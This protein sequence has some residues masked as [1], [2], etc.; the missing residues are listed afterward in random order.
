MRKWMSTWIGF[1]MWVLAGTAARAESFAYQCAAGCDEANLRLLAEAMDRLPPLVRSTL[2]APVAVIFEALPEGTAGS[3]DLDWE[4]RP[5]RPFRMRVHSG[6]DIT[7]RL[8]SLLHETAHLFD[9]GQPL[10]ESERWQLSTCRS[11]GNRGGP[12][13]ARL[14]GKRG[15]YSDDAQFQ[16][17]AGWTLSP[18]GIA[19]RTNFLETRSPDRYEFRDPREAFAVNFEYFLLDPEFACRRPAMRRYLSRVTGADPF[20]EARCRQ[21]PSEGALPDLSRLAEVQLL[22]ATPGEETASRWGHVMFRLVFC[23]PERREVSLECRKDLSEH[24]IISPRATLDGFSQSAWKLLT[25]GYDSQ[26]YVLKFTQV[27]RQYTRHEFRDL[28]AI[29]LRLSPEE[30]SAFGQVALERFW[31]YRG[32]YRLLSNNCADE[33]L[34]LLQAALGRPELLEINPPYLT[35][36][37]LAEELQRLGLAERESETYASRFPQLAR[38]VAELDPSVDVMSLLAKSP[39]AR[40]VWGESRVDASPTLAERQ[41]RLANL[42]LVE[43]V[44]EGRLRADLEQR[45]LSHWWKEA[46]VEARSRLLNPESPAAPG[47]GIPQAGEREQGGVD[48]GPEILALAQKREAAL[49]SSWSSS[50]SLRKRWLSELRKLQ[51]G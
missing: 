36:H 9:L 41:A 26:V 3:T 13:C 21:A 31:T 11:T 4:G 22:L 28:V 37:Q 16:A 46:P 45:T 48:L 15:K 1:G 6:L 32:R 7:T 2:G 39:A 38:A 51:A 19:K 27:L 8:R 34:A 24:R 50:V 18:Y 17:L 42:A 43:D 23:A 44:A 25:G 49:Y 47:Y 10:D 29:P 20:P 33:S 35:P 5:R 12:A 40:A 14:A 30:V